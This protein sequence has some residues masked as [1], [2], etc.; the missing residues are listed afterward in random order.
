MSEI[1]AESLFSRVSTL[2]LPYLFSVQTAASDLSSSVYA[3]VLGKP[4]N[5]KPLKPPDDMDIL[6]FR[7]ATTFLG[8]LPQQRVLAEGNTQSS[9]VSEEEKWELKVYRAIAALVVIDAEVVA[10]V[11]DFFGISRLKPDHGSESSLSPGMNVLVAAKA[12]PGPPASSGY[13]RWIFTLIP[14]IWAPKAD[15]TPGP[16][17]KSP[18][19][20]DPTPPP[21]LVDKLEDEK[22]LISYLNSYP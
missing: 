21:L 12:K 8:H 2:F 22:A 17:V 16:S 15:S 7:T 3:M 4:K 10:V 18:T 1:E 5:A 19:F 9:A 13:L 11:S 14:N 6:A 20:I